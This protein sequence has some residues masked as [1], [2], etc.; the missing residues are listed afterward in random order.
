LAVVIISCSPNYFYVASV[1]NSTTFTFNS[2]PAL[3][4]AF[5]P[6]NAPFASFPGLGFAQVVAVGDVNSGGYPFTGGALYPSPTVYG[7]N[8][9]TSNTTINGPAIQ[10]AYI[11][12]TSQGFI[13]GAGAGTAISSGVLVGAN[14]NVIYWEA[15][16]SD[17]AAN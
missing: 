1:T 6:A 2:A 11:N 4:T 16:L 8:S 5:N 15:F 10:G 9:L 14:T 12:N 13:I 3:S 7:G 17:Y